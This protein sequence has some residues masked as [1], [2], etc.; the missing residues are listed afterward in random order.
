MNL[1]H[2]PSQT[3]TALHQGQALM[4]PIAQLHEA[5]N[6]LLKQ[7]AWSFPSTLVNSSPAFLSTPSFRQ[8][9]ANRASLFCRFFFYIQSSLI[10]DLPANV[11]FCQ[12]LG[13][14]K[15]LGGRHKDKE[16]T[17][18]EPG[19]LWE[20]TSDGRRGTN[21]SKQPPP[22]PTRIHFNG[23]FVVKCPPPND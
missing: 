19:A 13:G 3:A 14:P 15:A 7:S 10:A 4:E 16:A 17:P 2:W 22:L 9:S 11:R 5:A 1:K 8:F 23:K 18:P 21:A 20:K 12:W 6:L